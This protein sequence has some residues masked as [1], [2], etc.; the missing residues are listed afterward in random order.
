MDDRRPILVTG[1]RGCGASRVAWLLAQQPGVSRVDH[2]L[3]SDR[4]I[5]GIERPYQYIWEAAPHERYYR[6][7]IDDLLA[8]RAT[9]R[10]PTGRVSHWRRTRSRR[11]AQRA[12]RRA[13]SHKASHRVLI[14]D[15]QAALASEYLHRRFHTHVLVLI[16]HPLAYVAGALATPWYPDPASLC[17]QPGL[18][19]EHMA[20]VPELVAAATSHEGDR[21]YHAAVMWRCVYHVLTRFLERNPQMLAVRTSDMF[22][23]ADDVYPVVF[24]RFGLPYDPTEG[25]PYHDARHLPD[26]QANA[27]RQSLTAQQVATIRHVTQPIARLY[28]TDKDWL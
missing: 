15:A 20:A 18:A 7:L 11:R 27:W 21:V 6:D 17:E 9:Y 24:G 13:V 14:C 19:S 5:L 4:G 3:S 8:G 2:P 25:Y 10:T 22:T 26:A 16:S 23:Q 12:Y 28:F 1:I